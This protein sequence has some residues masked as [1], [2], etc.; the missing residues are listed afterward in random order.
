[1]ESSWGLA[2]TEQI[3][4]VKTVTTKAEQSL[5]IEIIECYLTEVKGESKLAKFV[6]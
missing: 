3:G 4:K 2:K 1:M 6:F 5:E